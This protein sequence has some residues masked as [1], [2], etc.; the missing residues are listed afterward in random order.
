[1]TSS[2]REESQ[3]SEKSSLDKD[4]TP[5]G[6]VRSS[7]TKRGR[8]RTSDLA[9]AR[10]PRKSDL[11]ISEYAYSE[12]P[13]DL[14]LSVRDAPTAKH[15]GGK[16]RKKR[17]SDGRKAKRRHISNQ[18]ARTSGQ[19][20]SV[21]GGA[22][23][24]YQEGSMAL[25]TALVEPHRFRKECVKQLE[26]P[27]YSDLQVLVKSVH[28]MTSRARN[29]ELCV[30][31]YEEVIDHNGNNMNLCV[32]CTHVNLARCHYCQMQYESTEFLERLKAP[33]RFATCLECAFRTYSMGQPNFCEFCKRHCAWKSSWTG[34]DSIPSSRFRNFCDMCCIARQRSK[35]NPKE[36]K[37]CLR[38]SLFA[39]PHGAK[40]VCINCDVVRASGRESIHSFFMDPAVAKE[41]ARLISLPLEELRRR[42][43]SQK[44]EFS[45]KESR[46]QELMNRF[47]TQEG[48]L[49]S[50]S[51]ER[52][53]AKTKKLN[54]TLVVKRELAELE[55]KMESI[56]K[57]GKQRLAQMKRRL[58]DDRLLGAKTRVR[59]VK[60]SEEKI[61]TL[62]KL[63]KTIQEIQEL[64]DT[65]R[66]DEQHDEDLINDMGGGV[67][68][69]EE[70]QQ[71]QPSLEQQPNAQQDEG[72]EAVVAS[73]S[74]AQQIPTKEQEANEDA[75]LDD[76]FRDDDETQLFGDMEDET[77]EAPPMVKGE[78]L[79][80]C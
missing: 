10:R 49:M 74:G 56:D 59:T 7:P 78:E 36:C 66:V 26:N 14:E 43:D 40:S 1:M 32:S 18:L 55:G 68:D 3:D 24:V 51:L 73:P 34:C 47:H 80:A 45:K 11:A 61:V 13:R 15:G 27:D 71:Q 48:V 16:S 64:K 63:Q 62:A 44:E 38:S 70:Q 79:E 19:E 25:S 77:Q 30:N 69:N 67:N 20:Q 37:K 22:V 39:H 75:D 52:D 65:E 8:P 60:E 21:A 58:E 42:L 12:E 76:L 33:G 72:E 50:Y 28:D 29:N 53:K 4:Y 41:H 17:D 57:E 23:E 35:E 31:C 6:S 2:K 54:E 9:A 46:H 5:S